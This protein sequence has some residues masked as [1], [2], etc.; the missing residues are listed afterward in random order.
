MLNAIRAGATHRLVWIILGIVLLGALLRGWAVLRLPLDFDEPTYLQAGF[1][2]AAA[3]RAGDWNGVI[4]YA[5]N[6]EHPAL[7][8]L[9]Y[10]VT[11]L[12][13]GPDVDPTIALIVNRLVSALCGVLAVLVLALFDPLAGALLAGHTLS[14]K[15]TSQVYLE[16]LPHLASLVAVL[17]LYRSR[18]A[19][20]RWFW[21]S[22]VALGVTAASKFTYLPIVLVILY[23]ARWEKRT[24]WRDLLLYAVL[25]VGVFG[26]LDPTL[27]HDPLG[28]LADTLFFHVRYSQSASVEQVGYPW[29]QPLIW[30][31]SAPAAG[32]HP[33]V[34]F[35]FALDGLIGLLAL[36]GLYWEWRERRW[37]VVW[38]ATGVLFLLVWPTKWPQYSLILA[39][40][41]CLAAS[42][43]VRHFIAWFREQED[44]WAWARVIVIVPPRSFWVLAAILVVVIGVGYTMFALQLV[45]GQ[46]GWSHLT[47]QNTLLPSNTVYAIV[48]GPNEQMIL[49]TEHG[50]AIWSPPATTDLPAHW[51][52]F[53]TANSDLP[54]DRVLAIARA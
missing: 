38:I 12:A 36:A 7:V 14:I 16:A 34:F 48:A 19:R 35:Y 13:L 4:D 9:L 51:T 50:A 18:A 26:L 30:L 47:A 41:L 8:K 10:G 54:N 32:W 25:A 43:T 11:I 31:S 29:Y 21:L 15:Y 53:T 33:E 52:V 28:R 3:L 23:M 49:G 24:P 42:S 20:D 37:V 27:W 6:R 1:D 45:L 22:A 39:P 40:A 46:L 17:A 2:Y 5:G 44:Y